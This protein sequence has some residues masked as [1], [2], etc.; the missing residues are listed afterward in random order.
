MENLAKLIYPRIKRTAK[1]NTVALIRRKLENILKDFLYGLFF[2]NKFKITDKTG[3]PKSAINM[4][5]S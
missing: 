4:D 1:N 3:I 5:V 2:R